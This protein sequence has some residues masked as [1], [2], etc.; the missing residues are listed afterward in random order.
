MSHPAAA[1]SLT[2]V[3]MTLSIGGG[4]A[5]CSIERVA[6]ASGRARWIAVATAAQ[7]E[8]DSLSLGSRDSHAVTRSSGSDGASHSA[9]TVVL[10]N[11]GGAEMSVNFARSPR[12]RRVMSRARATDDARG[13]G[14]KNLVS[15]RIRATRQ[16]IARGQ[17]DPVGLA[18]KLDGY[19]WSGR[20]RIRPE[21]T[22]LIAEGR[23]RWGLVDSASLHQP[24]TP[25]TI[26][27]ADR[28]T[29]VGPENRRRLTLDPLADDE[30]GLVGARGLAATRSS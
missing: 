8:P 2:S 24:S 20:G 17:P 13:R 3:V 27:A 15:G 25:S 29:A 4:W 22:C 1:S 5:S 30:A 10:P 19:V 7:K 23:R 9:S 14:T 18:I 12:S 26:G 11:P 21:E 16:G 28:L 6:P